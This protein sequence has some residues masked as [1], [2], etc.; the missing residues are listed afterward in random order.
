MVTDNNSTLQ[1]N[2]GVWGYKHIYIEVHARTKHNYVDLYYVPVKRTTRIHKTY[3]E[4]KRTHACVSYVR[5]PNATGT[6]HYTYRVT[7][8][9]LPTYL[10]ANLRL[11]T[12]KVRRTRDRQI[13]RTRLGEPD[14]ANK[15][16]HTT[17]YVAVRSCTGSGTHETGE[18]QERKIILSTN[19]HQLK[20]TKRSGNLPYDIN[21]NFRCRCQN[22]LKFHMKPVDI[23]RRVL[24]Y[25][26]YA[27][28][29]V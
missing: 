19:E 7:D 2:E 25:L 4:I 27:N 23:Y 9:Y 17:T 1:W 16:P 3:R 11:S 28:K 20:P 5:T 18:S 21:R 29:I 13:R 10:P 22:T 12:Y 24:C 15:T 6:F 14:Y 26:L 8:R